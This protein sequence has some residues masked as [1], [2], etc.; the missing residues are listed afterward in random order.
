MFIA[1]CGKETFMEK[2]KPYL[3]SIIF[4][5]I[6]VAASVMLLSNINELLPPELKDDILLILRYP[7]RQQSVFI[8]KVFVISLGVSFLFAAFLLRHLKGWKWMKKIC[9]ILLILLPFVSAE[10]GSRIY[11]KN[12]YSLYRPHPS[13]LYEMN[14][15]RIP[16]GDRHLI[17]SH[18]FAY[19]EF[20]VK[21]AE[22]EYRFILAGDSA[23]Y[24]MLVSQEERYSCVLENLLQERFPQRKIRVINA[25]HKGATTTIVKN[26]QKDKLIK[27]KPD[28]LIIAL[29][30]DPLLNF[31]SDV[32][33]L[34]PPQWRTLYRF[35]YKSELF[36]LGRKIYL[37]HQEAKEPADRFPYSGYVPPD[38][39]EWLQ[40]GR[41][42][43]RVEK[44]EL[45][46]NYGE[47]I[48]TAHKNNIEVMVVSMPLRDYISLQYFRSD[49]PNVTY[50]EET[51]RICKEKDALF[52]D[53][54]GKWNQDPHNRTLFIDH[55]HLTPQG[56]LKLAEEMLD[57]IIQ[58]NLIK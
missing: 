11:L 14:P 25:S 48:D 16:W 45:S 28:C 52:V 6:Y 9:F 31:K 36:L 24:S 55:F 33:M 15:G 51:G 54:F 17:N 10:I 58:N 21:K 56:H 8:I 42:V 49:D 23:S 19:E 7:P 4:L 2:V 32:H 57:V 27:L 22:N 50:K 37:S 41:G 34:P 30:N 40:S 3:F 53:L 13:T 29:N 5:I 39:G 38:K 1:G 46:S 20:S 47:I 43:F 35:L 26:L 44:E 18:G 12:D